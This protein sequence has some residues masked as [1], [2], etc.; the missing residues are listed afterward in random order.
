MTNIF[1]Q[2]V[3]MIFSNLIMHVCIFQ[4]N[5]KCYF[6]NKVLVVQNVLSPF[7]T[8]EIW[9]NQYNK[10]TWFF[11]RNHNHSVNLCDKG[12]SFILFFCDQTIL[13]E[14]VKT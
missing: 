10:N 4:L 11:L 5:K 13:W 14:K 9:E 8:L 1:V 3:I 2:F 7:K 6:F 12:L